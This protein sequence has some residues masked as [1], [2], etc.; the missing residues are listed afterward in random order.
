LGDPGLPE[1]EREQFT[2]L[3]ANLKGL[4]EDEED[5]S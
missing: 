3:F 1:G 2:V 4:T 5:R